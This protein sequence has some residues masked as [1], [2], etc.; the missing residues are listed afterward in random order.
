MSNSPRMPLQ[1]LASST[2]SGASAAAQVA[3]K[4]ASGGSSASTAANT[5]A[6]AAN[7][8]LPIIVI[9]KLSPCAINMRP[10]PASRHKPANARGLSPC[11]WASACAASGTC[12][13]RSA[14]HGVDST[15]ISG[16]W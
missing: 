2:D 15:W 5:S 9:S 16:E 12:K 11:T 6:L 14:G 10:L 7:M 13:G 3:G 1:V 4:G 8:A